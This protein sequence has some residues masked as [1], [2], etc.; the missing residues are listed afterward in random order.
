MHRKI[1]NSL[2]CEF[3]NQIENRGRNINL[4]DSCNFCRNCTRIKGDIQRHGAAY[5]S[6]LPF[7][8]FGRL[9]AERGSDVEHDVSG[10]AVGSCLIEPLYVA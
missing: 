8:E 5:C 3:R 9:I 1:S 4:K 2:N 10:R 7:P 6:Y